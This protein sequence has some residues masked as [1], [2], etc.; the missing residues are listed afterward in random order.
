M[1]FFPAIKCFFVLD[2]DRK[3]ADGLSGSELKRFS[4]LRTAGRWIIFALA[5][6][7]AATA[8][9]PL[10][11]SIAAFTSLAVLWLGV[12]NLTALK[13]ALGGWVWGMG[14]A[15]CSF[16][17]LREINPAIPWLMM[18]VLGAYYI[19]VGWIGAV[20]NR[21]ILLPSD[22]RKKGFSAQTA[23]RDF[24]LIRQIG[25]TLVCGSSLVLVEYLRHNVLPWNYFGV[26]FYRN[27]VLMQL[28]RYTGVFGLSLLAAMFNAALVLAI[29]TIVRKDPESGR[30]RYRRPLVLMALL[31]VLAGVMAC[32]IVSLKAR[33]R[34][35]ADFNNKV[36]MTL[37]QGDL[38]PG[39]Y[40]NEEMG[41]KT[42]IRYADLT[43]TQKGVP[44]DVVVWPETAVA[45]PL[46]GTYP[47]SKVYRSLVRQL[48]AELNAP[49]LLG[50]LEFDESTNPPGSLNS[51]VLTD[52][53][54]ILY[55]GYRAIYSKVH[56]VPFGEFV[57]MRRYLP[58]WIIRIID[59][60]RDLTPGKSLDP[61]QLNDTIRLG[62]SICFEDV[63]AY[64]SRGEYLRGANVLLVIADDA[65]YP[66]S[67]EPEQHLAN[68]VARAIETG[69]P[70]VRCG[71]DSVT[72]LIAP[73][74]EVIWSLA[75]EA[76]LGN[77]NVFDR[78]AGAATITVHAPD[79]QQSV[80]TFYTRFGDWTVA[81]CAII[82]ALAL[83]EMLRCRI[84]FIKS[85]NPVL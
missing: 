4:K 52:T 45:Y 32:G 5:G 41:F 13:A 63:F 62:V 78:G 82:M 72:C 56:P 18:V 38:H 58:D 42:L 21:Y 9:P 23:C 17:W 54:D 22:I 57:P 35:Y 51:A 33:R 79:K 47:V 20:A 2:N 65:W 60:N 76:R 24:P 50:T 1:K 77:G 59:M 3:G 27:T 39:R 85:L 19:P 40:S 49:M 68:A 26:A 43:R 67:S 46:R 75:A 25:W 11:W 44:T 14:Y 8:F 83:L 73:S 61:I 84:N 29:L 71:N 80:M 36:R 28:V 81:L 10:N 53:R 30:L 74:G 6:C 48:S 66:T 69:L 15:L 16:F 34:E 70:M 12:R 37:V 31:L 64:I 7:F 55:Y